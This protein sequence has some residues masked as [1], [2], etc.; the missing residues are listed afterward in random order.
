M[1]EYIDLTHPFGPS[2]PVYPGDPLSTLAQIATIEKDGFVDHEINS[3]MHVGTHMDAPW[4]MLENGK[5]LSAISVEK[6]FG[7]GVL[8]DAHGKEKIGTELLS[9]VNIQAND[10]VLI[11]TGFD[12]KFRDADYFE[13]YPELT[14]ELA[15][16]FVE[17]KVRALGTDTPSPDQAPYKVHKILLK[18]EILII[19]N[20]TNLEQLIGKKFELTALPAKFETEA[21]PVRVIAKIL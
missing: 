11:L 8:I 17:L 1:T 15:Q 2:M 14:E 4:H 13:K 21:A 5:K 9:Q 10:I 7:R 12:K 3:A 18:A 6:F 16:K 20:L 19:E